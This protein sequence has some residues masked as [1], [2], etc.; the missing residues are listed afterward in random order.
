M[1]VCGVDLRSN[2]AIVV[3][4]DGDKDSY[5]LVNT[6]TSKI[7]L[8]D[9]DNQTEIRNF[10]TSIKAYVQNNNIEKIVI[11]KRQAKGK[12][13]GGPVSFKI[14]GLF[15]LLDSAIV[16]LVSPPSIAAK[17]KKENPDLPSGLFAYQTEAFKVAFTG[18]FL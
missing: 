2:S 5:Q 1:R 7:E 13:A 6:G 9:P 3:V 18:F 15:Q 8:N 14:E 10:F 11:K 17:M 4:L 16:I 12:F